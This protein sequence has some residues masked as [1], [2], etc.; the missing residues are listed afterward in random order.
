[1]SK[2]TTTGLPDKSRSASNM[3]PKKLSRVEQIW[4]QLLGNPSNRHEREEGLNRL[5]VR[6][7]AVIA[8]VLAVL[9]GLS[10]LNDQVLVPNQAVAS[11]N[12]EAITVRQFRDRI[13]FEEVTLTNRLSSDAQQLQQFGIDPNQYFQSQEPYKTYI[14][15]LNFPDQL[16][17]RVLE[18]MIKD[19]LAEQKAGELGLEITQDNIQNRVNAFFNYDPT[20][21]ALTGA[22][23]TATTEPTITP[24]PF[25]SPT[26][27]PPPTA[28]PLPTNTPEATAEATDLVGEATAEVTSEATDE[29]T[30]ELTATLELP[31]FTPQP[32]LSIEEQQTQL[33][34]NITSYN[35]TIRQQTGIGQD[36]IDASFRRE[37]VQS[38]ISDY[39]LGSENKTT[40]VRLRHI[41]VAT[42]EE[43]LDV[44]A[45]LKSGTSFADL[46]AA[47]STDTGSAQNGGLYDWAPALNYVTAFKDASLT[48]PIGQISEPIKTEFGYHVMQVISREDR[49]VTD[50]DLDRVKQ[51]L[52]TQWIDQLRADSAANITINDNWV[53]Y[54][55]LPAAQ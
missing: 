12:G 36:T 34:E 41:L 25:V 44:I 6:S 7:V 32:T 10:V 16:G 35:R 43:A 17:Q 24:T 54:V 26:P 33:Q 53:N 8:I 4:E 21:V 31:T 2:R 52:Y 13:R 22:E 38:A 11:V 3:P 47:V 45:A 5:I 19:K 15:E 39:L 51:S 9:I 42:E 55:P 20:Q 29:V 30:A 40:Y 23:P 1:M 28:T 14:N 48:L 37:A 27:T 50:A 46:A 18:D 49:E